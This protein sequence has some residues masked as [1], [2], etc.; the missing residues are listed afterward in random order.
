LVRLLLVRTRNAL[1]APHPRGGGGTAPLSPAPAAQRSLWLRDPGPPTA[2]RLRIAARGMYGVALGGDAGGVAAV[3]PS[4]EGAAGGREE[5]PQPRLEVRRESRCRTRG[6]LPSAKPASLDSQLAVPGRCSAAGPGPLRSASAQHRQR[7]ES[8]PEP[9]ARTAPTAVRARSGVTPRARSETE[10][11][12]DEQPE[13]DVYI[14]T[15]NQQ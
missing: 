11:R 6:V 1:R 10:M 2:P 5:L 4:R 12:R 7:T 3:S 13:T 9:H 14:E 15:T 8:P